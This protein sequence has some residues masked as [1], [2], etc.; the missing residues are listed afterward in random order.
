[1]TWIVLD[2][3]IRDEIFR[4]VLQNDSIPSICMGYIPATS[5]GNF[6]SSFPVILTLWTLLVVAADLDN[7]HRPMRAAIW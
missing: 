4:G 6:P 1:M 7:H 2:G 5:I 3:A